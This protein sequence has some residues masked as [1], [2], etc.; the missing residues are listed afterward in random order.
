[1][2]AFLLAQ[3]AKIKAALSS[4]NDKTIYVDKNL[5]AYSYEAGTPG[6]YGTGVSIDITKPGYRPIAITLKGDAHPGAGTKIPMIKT[7]TECE[8]HIIRAVNAEISISANDAMIRVA[9]IKT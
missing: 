9:Y 7:D 4:L 3:I 1:M 2:I 5:P 6:T 8:V